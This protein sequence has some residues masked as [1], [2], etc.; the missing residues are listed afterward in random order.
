MIRYQLPKR[1]LV[2]NAL[3]LVGPLTDA[4]AAVMSLKT[5]PFQRTWAEA[6]QQVQLKFEVAGTSRIEGADF[7]ERELDAA[8]SQ[9]PHELITRSQRQAHAA[10]QTYRWIAN[11]EDDRPISTDLI[12]EVHRQIVT[13]ADDD[14]CP[15]GEI[16]RQ[17]QN[18]TFGIPPHRGAEGGGECEQ[19]FES[20]GEALQREFTDHDLLIQALA[21]HYHFAAI[22]PFLDGNGRTARALEALVLQRAGLRDALFIAMSNYYYDEKKT[23]LEMLG[24]VRAGNHDLTPFLAFGLRGIASQ[25]NRLFG[26]IRT[27]IAKEMFRNLMYDLFDRLQTPKKRVIAKRQIEILKLLLRREK[28]EWSEFS[29]MAAQ[30]HKSL[31]KPIMALVRDINYLGSLGAVIVRKDGN[32]IYLWVNLDWPAQITE[33]EFFEKTRKFS[34][35]KPHSLAL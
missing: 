8:L 33:T 24:K 35:A 31:T 7:T 25:C 13:G 29:Q 1:W 34:K 28:V 11:L 21:L 9:T 32:R 5:I 23:Y 18:V 12:K 17:D 27:N 3:E 20:L 22:H 16:R 2:Y 15:P 6:L 14:I 10:V 4:K 26:V 19:A 30:I